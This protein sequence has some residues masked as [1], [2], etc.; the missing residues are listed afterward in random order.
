MLCSGA[1]HFTLTV[2]ANCRRNLTKIIIWRY[3]GISDGLTS[4][5]MGLSNNTP[6]RF[7]LTETGTGSVNPKTERP[8]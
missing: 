1:R 2:P 5:P 3:L 7:M 8:L 6:S 4:H